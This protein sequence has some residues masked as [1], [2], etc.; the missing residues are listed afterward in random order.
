M[1]PARQALIEALTEQ[2]NGW[3]R[4]L[5][6]KL[7]TF[8]FTGRDKERDEAKALAGAIE[9]AQTLVKFLQEGAA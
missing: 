2:S 1:T 5:T 6:E 8:R 9:R 3:A 7:N 4:L